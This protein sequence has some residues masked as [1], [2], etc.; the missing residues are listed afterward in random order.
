MENTKRNRVALT[1]SDSL[2]ERLYIL[3]E[4]E[5]KKPTTVARNIVADFLETHAKEIEEAQQAHIT[6][7]SIMKNLHSKQSA[8]FD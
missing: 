7:S 5:G 1:L 8:M 2:T 4:I 3:A 6:Y